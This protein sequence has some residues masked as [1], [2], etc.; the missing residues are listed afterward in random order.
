MADKNIGALEQISELNDESL[1]VVEQNGEAGKMTGAQFKKYAQDSVEAEVEAAKKAAE[2]AAKI[3]AETITEEMQG[4]VQSATASQEAAA[5]SAASA[6]KDAEAV[7][8]TLEQA[9]DTAEE[10]IRAVETVADEVKGYSSHPPVIDAETGYWMEWNGEE[11]V[12][13]D[14]DSVGPQGPQGIQGETG[15]QGEQGIQGERGIQGETGPQGEQGI[16]GEVGPQGE[17]GIPGPA[18]P[19]GVAGPQGPQGERGINGVAVQTAG[20]VAFNVTED[21]M[22]QC[23]YSG[24]DA[25]NYSINEDGHLILEM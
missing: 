16:Q 24:D 6:Q 21:G 11:Y 10:Y 19:Q 5:E 4:Y 13:T 3:A 22:L 15:P 18:G 20:H 17:Q 8:T 7:N 14:N 23:S 25:P 9:K 12:V 2:E 1:L